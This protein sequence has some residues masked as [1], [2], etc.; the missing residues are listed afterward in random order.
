MEGITEDELD[1]A[2]EGEWTPRRIV[3]HLA[4]AEMIGAIRLRRLLV[5]SPARLRGYDEKAFAETL[6][7]DRPIE[8]SLQALR[9][10]REAT[11]Q[12]LERMSDDDWKRVGEHDERGRYS[13]EDWLVLYASHAH[14]HAEQIKK[15]R[16]LRR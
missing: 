9:W 7:Q 13:T 15:T 10:V 3:H 11:T 16:G 14:D 12:L 8:P 6:T 2:P 4:D 5:E 1:R